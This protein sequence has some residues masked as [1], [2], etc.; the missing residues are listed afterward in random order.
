MENSMSKVLVS[1]VVKRALRDIKADPER[2]IRNLV[3]MA[4]QFSEGR[5]QKSFF[6]VAQKMLQD[7]SSAYYAL[8]SNVVSDVDTDR[9][10]TFGMNLGY[11]GCTVG[12]QRIRDHEKKL[13]CKIPWTV[14]MQIDPQKF[15]ENRECY[16]TVIQDGEK[17]GIYVWMLLAETQ[18][19][20]A[21]PLVEQHPDSAFC[22]FCEQKDLTPDFL[23]QAVECKNLMLVIRYDETA[24][25]V[26]AGLRSMGLLYSVWYPYKA[27]D[28]EAITSGDLFYAAQ[29]L[30]PMFT[31]LL[32][33]PE[34]PDGVR[35]LV[36]QAVQ[37]ARNEQRYRTFPWELQG[38]NLIVDAII[39][40]DTCTV[41]FDRDGALCTW[42]QQVSCEHNN[43][44][45]S[46]LVD[47]LM[48]AGPREVN[49]KN[50]KT[51]TAI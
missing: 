4:L 31:A 14:I 7:E 50:D 37:R 48:S 25:E 27:T 15:D 30:S 51:R 41:C 49:S 35:R 10:Y 40:D 43:L 44:F 6:T 18:P 26:C 3:D 8:I 46:S 36:H 39:S 13:G 20:K 12:A 1:A 29:Q 42:N 16:H 5:F 33:E 38:D 11:N 23:E 32:P 22:L 2:G 19:Q 45:Q 24:A 34:C 28:A 17:L 9:I 47:I 21:L